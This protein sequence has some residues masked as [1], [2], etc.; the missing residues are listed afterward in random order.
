MKPMEWGKDF[1]IAVIAPAVTAWLGGFE[2]TFWSILALILIAVV[3][4]LAVQLRRVK[5]NLQSQSAPTPSLAGIREVPHAETL[6]LRNLATSC[7]SSFYFL[8]VSGNRTANDNALLES[9]VALARSGGDVRF[10]LFAPSSSHFERRARDEGATP[11]IWATDIKATVTRINAF[12]LQHNTK[13]K[14]RYYDAYPIWR[15]V[16]IDRSTIRL[17]YF[18]DKRRFTASPTLELAITTDGIQQAYMKYFDELW[19]AARPDHQ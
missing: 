9:L 7:T 1:T 16:V 5:Q 18:L 6:N 10:L 8:G 19:Q 4:F 11:E 15:M 2:W 3:V 17:N 12:A 13:F 14:I